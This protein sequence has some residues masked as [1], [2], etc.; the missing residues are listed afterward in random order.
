MYPKNIQN[1][2]NRLSKLPTIG[3]KTAER[4]VMH[5]LSKPKSILQEL[6][7][8]FLGL[9]DGITTCI[10][11]GNF[12]EKNPCETCSN[13]KR[14]KSIICVVAKPQDIQAI[15]KTKNFNG[16]YHILGGTVNPL[17][18][19]KLEQLSTAPLLEKISKNRVQEI[20]LAFNPDIEGET[21]ILSL[22]RALEPYKLRITRL[23]RGLP[24]GSDIEYAD[25]VTL[26]DALQGRKDI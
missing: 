19:I 2:I 4:I 20:I 15:E 17:E 23:A 18:G 8:A 24:M 26:S 5:I 14:D 6:S 22:K 11:C 25:E 12:S 10:I 16:V 1:L 9:A 13:P 3:P 21:T 7:Q